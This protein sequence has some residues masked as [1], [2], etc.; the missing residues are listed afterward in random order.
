MAAGHFTR[1][2]WH[3]QVMQP[4]YHLAA[5]QRDLAYLELLSCRVVGYGGP[6]RP[7]NDDHRYRRQQQAALDVFIFCGIEDGYQAY[8][9]AEY[10]GAS[11]K[12]MTTWHRR[13]IKR[14]TESPWLA[15]RTSQAL[16]AW[17]QS[18]SPLMPIHRPL[19]VINA[20]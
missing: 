17:R 16:L 9:L 13:H 10:L 5:W 19:Q 7:R 1:F 11:D 14:C 15:R 12:R 3:V 6:L 2:R 18:R 4:W 20:M 8:T